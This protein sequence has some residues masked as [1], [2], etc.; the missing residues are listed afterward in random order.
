MVTL[1]LKTNSSVHP[2]QVKSQGSGI[3]CDSPD[4]SYSQNKLPLGSQ[5]A[6]SISAQL[7]TLCPV[8]RKHSLRDTQNNA[9]IDN[10][11]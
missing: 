9:F 5:T 3:S 7:Y 2:Q 8:L 6:L 4:L 1:E 11:L 10:C